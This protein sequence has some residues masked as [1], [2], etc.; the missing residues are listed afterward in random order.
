M[1]KADCFHQV[2]IGAQGAGNG[3]TDLGHFQGMGQTGAVL[4][5][6]IVNEYLGFVFQPA[7]GGRMDD[8]VT[9]PLIDSSVIGFI[10][11]IQPSAG[12]LA[13]YGKWSQL[14]IFQCFE[15]VSTIDHML[16]FPHMKLFCR[17]KWLMRQL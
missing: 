11:R 10:I 5:S 9:I 8:S 12:I 3:S 17:R 7:K 16:S 6:L 14:L 15:V 13:P 2:F 4:I 1:R